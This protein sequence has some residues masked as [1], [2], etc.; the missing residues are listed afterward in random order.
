MLKVGG[1]SF[2]NVFFMLSFTWGNFACA[3]EVNIYSARHYDT[4]MEMYYEFT[5]QTG[6]QV[7]LIEGS[8][9]ALIQR[10]LNEAELSSADLLITVDAG[11]LWRAQQEDLFQAIQSDILETKTVFL[12]GNYLCR[13][14][15]HVKFIFIS[16]IL[17]FYY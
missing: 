13:M 2:R 12:L 9:D 5:R 3:D 16:L 6:I 17:K 14:N 11:R 8:G 10:L 7:N 1:L 4:D 15:I